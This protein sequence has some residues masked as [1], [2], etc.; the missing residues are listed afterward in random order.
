MEPEVE[1]GHEELR[2]RERMVLKEEPE[3]KKRRKRILRLWE[4][5]YLV[6]TQLI[7]KCFFG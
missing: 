2:E 7:L 1:S 6:L 5:S 4:P 3:T